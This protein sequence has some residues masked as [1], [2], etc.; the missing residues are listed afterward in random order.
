M[1]R[2]R[3]EEGDMTYTETMKYIMRCSSSNLKFAN[4]HSSQQENRNRGSS[5]IEQIGL[6]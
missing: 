4:S 6:I 5:E 2:D 3:Y 1:L